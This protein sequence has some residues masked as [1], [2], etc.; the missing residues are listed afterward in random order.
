M[1]S[2][3]NE[4][5][6]EKSFKKLESAMDFIFEKT[7][8]KNYV[9]RG[10]IDASWPLIAKLHREHIIEDK[11]P[12]E[13]QELLENMLMSFRNNCIQHGLIHDTDIPQDDLNLIEEIAQHYG[14]PTRLLDW[15]YSPYIALC[16]AYNGISKIKIM[17]KSVALWGLDL[18]KFKEG[19][20]N[21]ADI[22]GEDIKKKEKAY[23]ERQE[24]IWHF[25]QAYK[26]VNERIRKQ[27]GTFLFCGCA[28]ETVDSF[29]DN[30]FPKD[31]LFKITL[32]SSLQSKM[33]SHLS[34]MGLDSASLMVDLEG[35]VTDTVWNYLR[36]Y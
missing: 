28:A 35:A 23:R 15:T 22:N 12:C 30:E 10:Q 16:F 25:N 7:S 1:C 14:M 2:T 17:N 33:L 3:K 18:D 19:I 6:Q 31:T 11:T 24:S 26:S 8:D 32:P 13:K 29:I 27:K 4:S 20:N 36:N 21:K 5:I 34:L 9:Y